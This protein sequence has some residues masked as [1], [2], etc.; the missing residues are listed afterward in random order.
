MNKQTILKLKTNKKRIKKII[1]RFLHLN[2]SY[3]V[4]NSSNISKNFQKKKLENSGNNC[5]EVTFQPTTGNIYTK[6][7]ANVTKC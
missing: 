3:L 2:N 5:T 6:K 7:G 1:I 4:L